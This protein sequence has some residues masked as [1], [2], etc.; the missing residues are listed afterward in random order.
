[1][2]IVWKEGVRW[3]TSRLFMCATGKACVRADKAAAMALCTR[4]QVC[5]CGGLLQ[6]IERYVRIAHLMAS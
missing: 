2:S 6:G 4:T 3:A 5:K 1:M